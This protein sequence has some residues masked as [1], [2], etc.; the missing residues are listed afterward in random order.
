MSKRVSVSKRSLNEIGDLN[1]KKGKSEHFKPLIKLHE[2]HDHHH[3][4]NK[5]TN[6]LN[7]EPDLPPEL[8]L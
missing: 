3:H 4:E 2:H 5:Y 1:M 7:V 6:F 8:T